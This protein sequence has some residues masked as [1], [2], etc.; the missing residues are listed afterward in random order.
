[1]AI[2]LPQGFETVIAH[3]AAYKIGAVA[4]PLALLF[5]ADAIEYR[6]NDSGAAVVVTNRFG[7]S[8]LQDIGGALPALK[9]VILT[10]DA[11]RAHCRSSA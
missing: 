10:G 6:L 1:M 11:G 7:F 9:H 8:K 5:G 3:V 4:L 2:L